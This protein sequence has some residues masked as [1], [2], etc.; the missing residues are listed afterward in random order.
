MIFAILQRIA[1]SL[2]NS[3]FCD[4]NKIVKETQK[5][6]PILEQYIH[7]ILRF[8]AESQNGNIGIERFETASKKESNM[9]YTQTSQFSVLGITSACTNLCFMQVSGEKAAVR[10]R[11]GQKL[12]ELR[13]KAASTAKPT[14]V[15]AKEASCRKARR[16][17]AT[18]TGGGVGV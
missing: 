16:P 2:Y 1:T 10:F 4:P 15:V 5:H 7:S 14:K 13:F 12:A 17:E 3:A 8:F 18:L 6:F 11:T 9:F